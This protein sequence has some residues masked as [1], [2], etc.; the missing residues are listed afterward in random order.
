[1]PQIEELIKDVEAK[2]MIKAARLAKTIAGE[3]PATLGACKN[4]GPQI[5]ALTQWATVFEHPKT[6][7][8]DIAKSMVFHRKELTADIAAVKTDWAAK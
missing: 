4:M 2:H 1:V 7:A 6:I 5:K 8:E 3:I